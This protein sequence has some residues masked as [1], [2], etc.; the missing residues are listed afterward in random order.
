MNSDFNL[1]DLTR[2]SCLE[3]IVDV[4]LPRW[5]VLVHLDSVLTRDGLKWESGARWSRRVEKSGEMRG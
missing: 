5:R 2:G 1:Q 3:V 4:K